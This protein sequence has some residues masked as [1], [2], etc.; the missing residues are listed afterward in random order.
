MLNE[1]ACKARL[2]LSIA[3]VKKQNNQVGEHH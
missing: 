1:I 2:H 3:S